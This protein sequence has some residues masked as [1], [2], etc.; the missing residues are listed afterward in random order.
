MLETLY[1]QDTGW[2]PHKKAEVNT[3]ARDGLTVPA[4]KTL[5]VL[6]IYIVK[7]DKSLW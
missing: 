2:K 6:L 4:S 5:A 1:T 3:G 7:S